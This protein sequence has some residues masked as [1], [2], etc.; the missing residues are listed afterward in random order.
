MAYLR[1]YPVVARRG[2]QQSA[3]LLDRRC[4]AI[5]RDHLL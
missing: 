2:I 4:L 1:L 5:L 3:L